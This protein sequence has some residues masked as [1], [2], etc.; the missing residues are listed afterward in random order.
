MNP[1]VNTQNSAIPLVKGTFTPS[2]TVGDTGSG[3]AGAA[4]PTSSKTSQDNKSGLARFLPTLGG[5]LGGGGALAAG[6]ALAP[7]TA[8]LSLIPSL[9]LAALGGG[10]GGGAGKVAENAA[11]KQS[12]TSGV[13]GSVI[14]NALGNLGGEGLGLAGKAVVGGLLPKATEAIGGG[15]FKGQF[16]KTLSS[17]AAKTLYGLGARTD[18]EVGQIAGHVTGAYGA[19]PEAIRQ[20]LAD[21][22]DAGH[23]VDLTGITDTAKDALAGSLGVKP[24]TINQ[25]GKT[26]TDAINETTRGDVK[27]IPGLKGAPGTF[28][29][30]PEA[31]THAN[32]TTV[33]DQVKKLQGLASTAYGRAYDNFGNVTNPDQEAIY[34]ALSGVSKDLEEKVFGSSGAQIPLSDTVK[35]ALITRLSPIK[36]INPAVYNNLVKSLPDNLQ[37]LRP[38]QA[39]FV[40]G[41]KAI[42][43]MGSATDKGIQAGDL[44]KSN[45]LL[46]SAGAGVLGNAVLGP[47]GAAASILPMISPNVYERVGAQAASQATK[48]LPNVGKILPALTRSAA[49]TA[50]N[51][52][53]DIASSQ[54]MNM[55]NGGMGG[56]INSGASM[57]Q[58]QNPLSQLYETLLAQE[59]ASPYN[60]ASSLGPVLNQLAPTLQ[61]QELAAPV[62]NNLL[63]TYGG[64]GGAQG[65]GGG[66]LSRLTGLI[67]GTPANTFQRQQSASAA[68]LAQILGISPE[69][70]QA[71]FPQLMQTPGAAAPQ[72]GG[73]QS[74][75]GRI[76]T[77]PAY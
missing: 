38:V 10:L 8:G 5:I 55:A 61:R 21:A 71:M 4:D 12:L 50:A 37:G 44:I 54:D 56:N 47:V 16:G 1:Q 23:V 36:D 69:Q 35:Q 3:V 41:S 11:E 34:K 75:L 64:A 26:I 48:L 42:Q 39:P 18:K 2:G 43:A 29:Y 45:R 76:A 6:A 52:P 32:P 28:S 14:S 62:I 20:G 51:L 70:A 19:Y 25:V 72:V 46:P 65:M 40:Q 13:E 17:D 68:S 49:V 73:L 24:N 74:I 63:E 53:N 33:F 30:T 77:A 7:E 60:F 22:E 31:L 59:Q 57:D 15:L 9:A 58:S 27:Y 67:P 66:L